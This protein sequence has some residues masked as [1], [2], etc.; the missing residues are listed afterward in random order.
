MAMATEVNAQPPAIRPQPAQNVKLKFYHSIG[1]ETPQNSPFQETSTC[2]N[3]DNSAWSQRI[4]NVS[5]FQEELKYDPYED[6]RHRRDGGNK[7]GEGNTGKKN[8]KALTFDE[9]VEVVP[10][11][12]RSEYSNRVKSRLW[13]NAMEIQENA[14]RN[15]LEFASEGWDWRNVLEDEHMYVCVA[16]SELIHPCHYEPHGFR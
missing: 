13:S 2:G 7:G 11:P 9:K 1:L 15:S 16:T 4:Q 12:M 5:T 6:K 3:A 14:A 10:I 8:K